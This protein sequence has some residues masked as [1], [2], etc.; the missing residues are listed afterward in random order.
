MPSNSLECDKHKCVMYVLIF[1]ACSTSFPW[2]CSYSVFST[3]IHALYEL[4]VFTAST[5]H[6]KC[7]CIVQSKVFAPI[8][9]EISLRFIVGTAHSAD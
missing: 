1:N 7:T 2:N 5:V 8:P 9:I 4:C 3:R 6:V